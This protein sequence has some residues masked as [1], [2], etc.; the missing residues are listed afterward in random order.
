MKNN[1]PIGIF[2]SG[3]G[4]MTV[5]VELT[6]LMPNESFIYVGDSQHFPYGTKSLEEVKSYG[7]KICNWLVSQGAKMII[8]ACNT[9]SVATLKVAQDQMS[10]PVIGV[11]KPGARAAVS[12][13]AN[14]R[15]GVLATDATVSAGAYEQAIHKFN[16]DAKVHQVAAPKLVDMAENGIAHVM[17]KMG[18][19]YDI[20]KSLSEFSEIFSHENMAIAQEYCVP[21]LEHKVDTVIMGCTHFAL[22]KPILNAAFGQSVMLVSSSRET[23]KDARMIL[24]LN[25]LLADG[26]SERKFYTTGNNVQ[27]YKEFGAFIFGEPLSNVDKLC[28]F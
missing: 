23:V 14:E 19:S 18:E 24:E 28:E 10:V 25:D 12:R 1:A 8:I 7:L 16:P 27:K 5:A 13:T 9:S 15:I 4:G 2:D 6:R 21:L 22:L 20:K 26:E 11:V 17:D 3:F